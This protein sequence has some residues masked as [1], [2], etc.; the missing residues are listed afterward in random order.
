MNSKMATNSELSTTAPKK[1]K[2]LNKQLEQEQ[3][4]RN[5]DCM[6]GYQWGEEGGRMGKN[7]QRIRSIIC[8]YKIG[9][10]RL[11]IV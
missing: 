8:R 6:E 2:K 3:D 7:A 1:Q 11:R 5:G 10:G 4:H 9:R